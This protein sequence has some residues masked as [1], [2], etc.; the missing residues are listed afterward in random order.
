MK[1]VLKIPVIIILLIIIAILSL[2]IVVN[3]KSSLISVALNFYLKKYN[4]TQH[5]DKIKVNSPSSIEIEGLS[6]KRKNIDIH[7]NTLALKVTKNG[8]VTLIAKNPKIKFFLGVSQ[9][10]KKPSFNIPLLVV[11]S[12]REGGE[13]TALENC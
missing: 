10:E 5:F 13:E 7:I 8:E 12:F 6:I 9:R 4:L 11:D 1:K 2:Y 3:L